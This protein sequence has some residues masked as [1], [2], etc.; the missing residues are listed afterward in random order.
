MSRKNG[1]L[2]CCSKKLKKYISQKHLSN[3][4]LDHVTCPLKLMLRSHLRQDAV[5]IGSYSKCAYEK[6]INRRVKAYSSQDFA[7]NQYVLYK[8]Y[9]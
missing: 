9:T 1:L 7:E 2:P 3:N 8:I 4:R 5:L 6:V